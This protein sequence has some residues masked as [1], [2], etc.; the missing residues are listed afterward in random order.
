MVERVPLGRLAAPAEVASV[1]VRLL[2]ADFGYV[3]GQAV[4]V[5]GG[6]EFD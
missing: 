4:N 6:L 5:C 3:T 1:A 2:G